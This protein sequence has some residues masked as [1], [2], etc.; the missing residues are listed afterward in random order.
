MS[1]GM[2]AIVAAAAV[3]GV[4]L[5]GAAAY[6]GCAPAGKERVRALSQGVRTRGRGFTGVDFSGVLDLARRVGAAEWRAEHKAP[7]RTHDEQNAEPAKPDTTARTRGVTRGWSGRISWR[8][9]ERNTAPPPTVKAENMLGVF[10][11]AGNGG[12][13]KSQQPSN[14]LDLFRKAAPG[15]GQQ[16]VTLNRPNNRPR[17]DSHNL[18]STGL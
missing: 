18:V 17:M 4:A 11:T 14:M 8:A 13:G 6:F 12:A 7:P 16:G 10:R 2:I 1:G 3:V 5:L 15:K 9:S